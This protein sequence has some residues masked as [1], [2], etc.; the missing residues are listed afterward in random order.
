VQVRERTRCRPAQ[1]GLGSPWVPPYQPE[2]GQPV[3]RIRAG[4][5]VAEV[6][7]RNLSRPLRELVMAVLTEG[8]TG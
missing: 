7:E 2:P 3:Y 8:G 6:A 5:N 4:K 1:A